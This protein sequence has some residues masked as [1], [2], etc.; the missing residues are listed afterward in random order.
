MRQIPN[1]RWYR[2]THKPQKN[3]THITSTQPTTTSW[4]NKLRVKHMLHQTRNGWNIHHMSPTYAEETIK[5]WKTNG[6]N[7]A[8]NYM[9]YNIKHRSQNGTWAASHR[10]TSLQL[11]T[12]TWKNKCRNPRHNKTP[13]HTEARTP[14]HNFQPR[15]KI[16]SFANNAPNTAH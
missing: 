11:P 4:I 6:G 10:K 14:T 12:W 16:D 8:N 9:N 5:M 1:R 7:M 3:R 15:R 2:E 13:R